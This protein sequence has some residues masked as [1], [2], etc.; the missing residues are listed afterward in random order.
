M[1]MRLN[2]DIIAQALLTAPGP[3][4]VGLSA[5]TP[6]LREAAAKDLAIVIFDLAG[7]E[8]GPAPVDQLRLAL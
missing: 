3:A 2:P 4:R 8:E 7:G 5:P 6:Y 1:D